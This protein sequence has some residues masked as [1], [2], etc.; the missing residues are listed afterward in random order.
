MRTVNTEESRLE[1]QQS[2]RAVDVK[3]CCTTRNGVAEKVSKYNQ[4]PADFG[5]ADRHDSKK[6]P[7]QWD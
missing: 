1:Q 3:E 2:E 4:Q 5:R 7:R 6:G